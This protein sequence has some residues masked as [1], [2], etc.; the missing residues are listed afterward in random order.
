[1]DTIKYKTFWKKKEVQ[2][3]LDKYKPKLR[4]DLKYDS[5]ADAFD[6]YEFPDGKLLLVLGFGNGTGTMYQSEEDLKKMMNEPDVRKS[7]EHVLSDLIKDDKKFLVKKEDYIK[8]LAKKLDLPFEKLNHSLASLKIIDSAYKERR[9]KMLEFFNE[10]YLYLIAY[11]G[12]VYKKEKGGD[13][14]FEKKAG[15]K[16]YEPYIKINESLR[17]DTYLELFK[18]CYE[19]FE[20]FS[21][22]NVADFELRE[23]KLS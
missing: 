11:L 10:D 23:N 3:L 6:Y 9:P 4:N 22:Y 12:E 7:A 2:V 19:H 1:M 20:N 13:W 15:N 16:S 21:T 14:Y 18:E 8:A 5:I 17:L